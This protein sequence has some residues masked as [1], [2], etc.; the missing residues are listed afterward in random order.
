[1][2]NLFYSIGP[3]NSIE[4]L[5]RNAASHARRYSSKSKGITHDVHLDG[6]VVVGDGEYGHIVPCQALT[7]H[8][9]AAKCCPE[10]SRSRVILQTYICKRYTHKTTG[11]KTSGFKTSGFKMSGFKTSALQNVSFTKRQVSKRLV[12]KRPVFKFDIL[13]NK[14]YWYCQVCIPI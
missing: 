12:S 7:Q 3:V 4:T 6:R 11:F 8:L 1:M 2:A 13:L 5:S 9:L 14:K 10:S